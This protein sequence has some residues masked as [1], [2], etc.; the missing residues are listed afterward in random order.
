M[1]A[2]K[3]RFSHV[4]PAGPIS[5]LPTRVT[6]SDGS[7]FLTPPRTKE[8]HEN[9]HH[10]TID[11]ARTSCSGGITTRPPSPTVGSMYT[12]DASAP[13][14]DDT[15]PIPPIK[16][17]NSN[18]NAPSPLL[19]RGGG[20]LTP[21]WV[22]QPSIDGT[23]S[24][25]NY[26]RVSRATGCQRARAGYVIFTV[27]WNGLVCFPLSLAGGPVGSFIIGWG[28]GYVGEKIISRPSSS[29]ICN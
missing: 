27:S 1:R 8:H 19:E 29:Q 26:P 10:C 3:V 28:C 22:M 16:R 21:T 20:L 17:R 25:P 18:L 15:Q 23:H 4:R 11:V 13:S 12:V 9:R 6:S 14:D 5:D 7:N 24:V 2:T